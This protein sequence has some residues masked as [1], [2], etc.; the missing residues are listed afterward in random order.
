MS[1]ASL[2]QTAE[3]TALLEKQ[4]KLYASQTQMIKG[5]LG[6]LKQMQDV[7]ENMNGKDRVSDLE[8]MNEMIEAAAKQMGDL[9][10]VSGDAM[11][12][13]T[14]SMQ[15]AEKQTEKT[16]MSM[17]KLGKYAPIIA[18]VGFAF[19]G[20][21]EGIKFSMNA[22]SSLAGIT[23][24]VV[25]SLGHLAI[26]ILAMPFKML[27][28]LIGMTEGGGG[29]GLR[30]ELENIR[31]EFG[32]L[33]TGASKSIIDI[34]RGMKGQL[35]ETGLS[36][37]KT[38]GNLAERLKTVAEYAKNMGAAF[39]LVAKSFVENGE[40][41]GAY[42]KGLGLTEKGQLALAQTAIRAGTSLQEVGREITTFAYGM[43]EAFGINGRQISGDIGEMMDDFE[44]FGNLGVQTLTNVSVFA[45][46]L[47][48]EFK[49]LQGVIGKFDNFEDAAQGAAQL[50]QAFG[51]QLDTLKLINAQDPA[52]R[53][54]MLRKSFFA[55]GRS[56]ENMTRQERAL[57]AT[58]TGLDQKTASLVF[59]M[60]NQGQSYAD[61]QKASDATQ[62]KQLTQAEAMEKL[63]GSIERLVK[64]GGGATGGFWDR[65]IQ[66]F[67]KG[68]KRSTEF[69]ELL[70]HLRQSLLVVHQAGVQV[71]RAFVDA[72]PGVKDMIKSLSEFF[73]PRRFKSA[74][75]G[76]VATFKKFFKGD[77]DFKGFQ[78][79]LRKNFTDF[80]DINSPSGQKF[81]RG[82]KAF[83][84]KLKSIFIEGLRIGM[85]AIKNG[86]KF[87]ADLIKDPASALA[88]TKAANGAGN[89]FMTEII[90]PI[91]NVIREEGP[92]MLDALGELLVTVFDFLKEKIT[93]LAI[94][95]QV[96][97]AKAFISIFVAPAM[98]G[99]ISRGIIGG[100]GSALVSGL[101]GAMKKGIQSVKSG[102]GAL[103]GAASRTS[104]AG[105]QAMTGRQGN[106]ISR[107]IDGFGSMVES[108]QRVNMDGVGRLFDVGA[109]M[110]GAGVALILALGGLIY[111][112][113]QFNFSAGDI[114]T[115]VLT[116]GSAL[117]IA[118]SIALLVMGMQAI[119]GA[120]GALPAA[121]LGFALIAATGYAV[122]EGLKLLKDNMV[123]VTVG[124]IA[125]IASIMLATVLIVGGLA[126]VLGVMTASGA[127]AMSTGGVAIVGFY[128]IAETITAGADLAKKSVDSF[129]QFSTGQLASV[130]AS[131]G[132]TSFL[133]LGLASILLTFTASGIL[134]MLGILGTIGGLA[135]ENV[136]DKSASLVQAA[137]N[138]FKDVTMDDARS[139]GTK[140]ASVAMIIAGLAVVGG[141]LLVAGVS[142]GLT[143]VAEW[144]G[145]GGDGIAE[146]V[147]KMKTTTRQIIG[148]ARSLKISDA[149]MKSIGKI[150]EVIE[151]VSSFVGI[152]STIAQAGAPS[153]ASAALNGENFAQTL[154]LVSATISTLP[155]QISGLVAAMRSIAAT[156][157]EEDVKKIGMIGEILNSVGSFIGSII[158]SAT[159]FPQ[160]GEAA[161]QRNLNKI[162]GFM[163]DLGPIIGSLFEAISESIIGVINAE[164]F[165]PAKFA[166]ATKGFS[167]A[168]TSISSFM[169]AMSE[170]A[171]ANA[172]EGAAVEI[173]SFI[174]GT[175]DAISSAFTNG[176]VTTKL[177]SLFDT[178]GTLGSAITPSKL[179]SIQ[180]FSTGLTT[181]TTAM[182]SIAESSQQITHEAMSNV[183]NTVSF[184]IASITDISNSINSL[185]RI[186][187]NTDLRRLVANVG[188]ASNE[189]LR[190]EHGNLK[191]EVN[192]NVTIEADKLETALLRVEN[193]RIAAL[194]RP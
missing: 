6:M 72:F 91:L 26:S 10:Q 194:V 33:R 97:L 155:A 162:K 48:V 94:K 98:L 45:R 141:A 111:I 145:I 192:L 133:I 130:G 171:K 152:Y 122:I 106:M 99:A 178:I 125:N 93:N 31:K 78:E 85:Q 92:A 79:A 83:F 168:L 50:S 159:S 49:D 164:G 183:T 64:S 20:M 35:A 81:Q 43:G 61:I 16:G 86:A 140:I 46:K 67:S 56:V 104:E 177:T 34:S 101:G 160:T 114:A 2:Q 148:A 117:L 127:L 108:A 1:D 3:L 75:D 8:D 105:S 74:M 134:G 118:G 59:S 109:A 169:S 11:S 68:I 89:F 22:M 9:G 188:L 172:G 82:A 23:G 52:E 44:N 166:A 73:D 147:T 47:G 165:D 110:A 115:T 41:I 113:K 132:A 55:A 62:K 173:G 87:L 5:Q 129:S 187:I 18:S 24:T 17:K 30:Q 190:L 193:G 119:G 65:F 54:E 60:E 163:R 181:V 120:M 161:L 156:V 58:Q 128:A 71:G 135:L 131:I 167:D 7:I 25:G 149:D 32:D 126:T 180:N 76:V 90:Q 123:G 14:Q 107:T 88:A 38:F 53:I 153:A 124:E 137:K 174:S 77:M 138:G 96:P 40:R 29:G 136:I 57:L 121:I 63:S 150:K 70:R 182:S 100:L 51:L 27:S 142:A 13:V 170:Q 186:N 154:G 151:V 103:G 102:A 19:D 139:T 146:L 179:K 39:N 42:I 191:I 176:D 185:G 189:R 184:M 36:T 158:K 21:T 157:T 69:R 175:I 28:G 4:N 12:K 95:Y 144:L 15:R 66:G 37:W 84:T 116:F 143:K 112:V 80:F